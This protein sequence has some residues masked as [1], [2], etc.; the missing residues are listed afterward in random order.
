MKSIK[1]DTL[2]KNIFSGLLAI[3][4]ITGSIS[5]AKK[6]VA[7]KETTFTPAMPEEKG[8][9]E[10]KRDANSNYVIQIN[11]SDLDPVKTMRPSKEAYVVWMVTDT[12][13]TKN[14]GQIEGAN[15][16]LSKK[17]KAS[18][19]AVT[20]FKPT[21]IFITAENDATIQKPG[22]QVVWATKSF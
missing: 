19:E 13:A 20:E 6:T 1:L 15:A 14:L 18:F 5:C 9:L 2:T 10:V 8:Q 11:I 3:A 17:N 12:K 7:A 22:T 16:W 4:M 21:K